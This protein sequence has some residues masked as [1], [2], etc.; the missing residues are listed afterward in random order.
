ML[1]E[2]RGRGVALPTIVPVECDVREMPIM[3]L[4]VNVGMIIAAINCLASFF[5]H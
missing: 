5:T 4:L 2:R 1:P 3:F